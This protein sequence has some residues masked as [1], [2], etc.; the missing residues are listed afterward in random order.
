MTGRLVAALSANGQ[1]DVNPQQ[2]YEWALQVT[3]RRHK[4]GDFLEAPLENKTSLDLNEMQEAAQSLVEQPEAEKSR[5]QFVLSEDVLGLTP[6]EFENDLEGNVRLLLLNAISE[7]AGDAI[8]SLATP[9]DDGTSEKLKQML[10]SEFAT[11]ADIIMES[12]VSKD[13]KRWLE[14]LSIQGNGS[15]QQKQQF[16]KLHLEFQAVLNSDITAAVVQQIC[17]AVVG[18]DEL[19][20]MVRGRATSLALLGASA[21]GREVPEEKKSEKDEKEEDEDELLDTG[22]FSLQDAF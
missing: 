14:T 22:A 8:A 1:K 15:A 19:Y 12:I 4:A 20:V 7:L 5:D 18:S 10:I 3:L 11:T 17:R 9:L 13:Y 16:E 6:E 2:A 21:K